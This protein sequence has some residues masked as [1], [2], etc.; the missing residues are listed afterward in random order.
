MT[1]PLRIFLADDHP[2]IRAGIRAALAGEADLTLVG[3]AADGHTAQQCCREL[4]PDVVVLDLHMPGPS[5]LAL[6]AALR[7]DHPTTKIIILT[8]HDDDAYVRGALGAGVAG[9]LLKDEGTEVI[10]RAI[11]VVAQG[12]TWFCPSIAA[13]L[14]RLAGGEHPEP[15]GLDL[16]TREAD[17]L[18]LVTAGKTNREIGAL[19]G[20]SE[21]TVEKRV[22]QLLTKLGVR[23]RV[24]AALRALREGLV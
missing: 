9:Y 24:E 15:I 7:G 14:A 2:L 5:P 22:S 8:A 19:L 11:R 12:G 16:T 1:G 3:E 13:R 23:T 18:R 21:K 6:I 10:A 4:A 20:V 17:V